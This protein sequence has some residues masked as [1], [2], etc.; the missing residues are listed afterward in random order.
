MRNIFLPLTKFRRSYISLVLFSSCC[1]NSYASDYV[2]FDS[3]FL[4]GS[5]AQKN[6]DI[7]RFSYGNPI[8]AGEY[9]ADVY[10]NNELR[11]RITLQFV[12]L[13]DQKSI[14]L[15]A[16]PTLLT[17][18]DLKSAAFSGKTH[19]V[20]QCRLFAPQVPEAKVNFDTGQLRLDVD[21]AQALVVQRPKGYISPAQWQDG[22]P[23][24]F[25]RYNA[26]H[27]RYQY[28]DQ[29]FYQSYL[30]IESGIN[31][32]GWA[33]RHRGSMSW[34]PQQ[35]SHYQ[36]I[37]TYLQHDVAAL[38]GQLTI[39]DLYTNGVL[40]D[41]LSLRGIKLASDD[42]MLASSERGYAP[43]IRGV[44]NSNAVV[45]IRQ[46][47]NLLRE[48][49]VPPGAFSIDDLF[50]TG[51]GGDI[52]VEI[53]E[54]NGEKRTF[55]VPY[56]AAAQ[57]IRP[58]YS[59]YQIAAGRYRYGNVVFDTNV[60]QATWQYGLTNNL[61]LNLGAILSKDYHSELLG[62][63]FNTPIGAFAANATLSNAT[64][65]NLDQKFK[66][67]NL[68]FSYNTHIEPTNTNVTL[69]A[70]RYLSR[71]YFSLQDVILANGR[72]FAYENG[73]NLSLN[74]YRP[75]NQF[76][77]SVSQ[78]FKD[79]WGGAYIT[80]STF[81]YWGTK[82]KRNEY[83]IGYSNNYK[84]LNYSLSFSQSIN[85]DGN[86]DKRIYLS[87]SLPL[88][89]NANG[90][91]LSQDISHSVKDGYSAYTSLF[92]SLGEQQRYTYTLSVSKQQ[93]SDV[94][95]IAFSNTYSSSFARLNGSWSRSN[96]GNQQM[97]VGASGAVVAHPK[98]ITL[99]NDLGDNFAIIHAKGAKGAL[100]NSSIGNEIDYF[101][102]GIVP[103]VEPYTIN[104][105]GLDGNNLPSS[106]EL[107][108]TEQQVIPRANQALLINFAT[109]AGSAVFFEIENKEQL[110]PLGTEVFDQNEKSIG[111][112]AQGG[113]IYT[114]G[115]AEKGELHLSWDGHHCRANYQ[116]PEQEDGKL[117]IVPIQCQFY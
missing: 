4:Y 109:T 64:F 82:Q 106:V 43:V 72:N 89:D 39:G 80:G 113:K 47:G 29:N 42:R 87:L 12:E 67:Y 53:L 19:Q 57:L 69:A 110:P 54:A 115:I 90:T 65:H 71:D 52:Q 55:T 6:I 76:Q 28:S 97:S 51:Y 62:L 41:S 112:V 99:S 44:A 27:Y 35:D 58:G 30:G 79:G 18:L 111:V 84:K 37:A 25:L 34:S 92:G 77:V 56:T 117:L 60:A 3:D 33:L 91:Y 63:S 21:I 2:E 101:G 85:N 100:I 59:R 22:I 10:V 78:T 66:G 45:S 98:G 103:Y 31:L 17:L 105:I 1:I 83:Q 13:S 20:K 70:Y 7:K 23:V 5:E 95:S 61:T 94:S 107:A 11:G 116:L 74:S 75:K 8:P 36:R 46:N 102:N 24:A 88:G 38:R 50:P 114:R 93:Q 68:Y 15:C 14:G 9:L 32:F 73:L 104:Y 16:T 48:V 49:S 96:K 40:M 108:A 86:N 81:T 26:S